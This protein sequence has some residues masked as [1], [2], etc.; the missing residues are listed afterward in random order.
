MFSAWAP[1]FSNP[2][3]GKLY[4][5]QNRLI[6]RKGRKERGGEG[7]GGGGG[8]RGTVTVRRASFDPGCWSWG[9][10]LLAFLGTDGKSCR[11]RKTENLARQVSRNHSP[12][13]MHVGSKAAH[14]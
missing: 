1:K 13:D 5:Q 2:R 11:S 6:G 7:G 3:S 8:V 12:L 4:G 9:T 14:L 10:D